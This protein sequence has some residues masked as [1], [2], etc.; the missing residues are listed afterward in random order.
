MC[1]YILKSF[2]QKNNWHSYCSLLNKKECRLSF[3]RILFTS[4]LIIILISSCAEKIPHKNFITREGNV[5]KD[6]D[7][8]FR[9]L[10]FNIPN[11]NFIEDEMYFRKP[12]PF[13]LPTSFEIRDAFESVKAMGGT[14]V[15]SY[16]FPVKRENDTLGIP[17]YVVGPGKFDESSFKVMDTVLAIA[18]E[19][20]I[21]LIV[22]L[23]NNWKWMGGVP[24]YA[25][26]RN[27]AAEEFW[28]D[29]LLI[30][31]FKKTIDFVLNREN[32][33]NGVA[34][35][36]DKSILC[37]ETGNELL[38]P[39]SW[40]KE[41]VSHI[42][43][44]DTN[45]LVMDGFNAIDGIDILEG[46]LTDSLV[47]IVSTHHYK[48]DPREIIKD[49]EK[50]LS[51]IDGRKPYII[52]EYGFL[53]TSAIE[54]ISDYL[55]KSKIAG[56]LL[57][58]LRFHREEGG[59]YWHSEPLGGDVFKAFH[60]P[61]F[62]SGLEYNE[63]ELMLMFKEKAY[64][65]RKLSV[66]EM[67]IPKPPILL[68]IKASS[69]ISW[70]GSV[71]AEYYDVQRSENGNTNWKTV[72]FNVSDADKFYRPLFDDNT[73]EVGKEYYYKITAKNISGT[74]EPSNIFGPVSYKYKTM[75]DE[76]ENITVIYYL[77]G[78]YALKN[79]N[80]RIFKEDA[81]RL[82]LKE[83]AELIYRVRGEINGARIFT[84]SKET[85]PSLKFEI[86]KDGSNYSGINFEQKSYFI[87]T[88][89]YSYWVPSEYVITP[90]DSLS[91]Y[92][93]FRIN[94]NGLNQIARIEIDYIPAEFSISRKDLILSLDK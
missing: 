66:P 51:R 82:E 78:E 70:K 10:S 18:D 34:Y 46:S 32:T 83:E 85:N 52:G 20:G 73:A 94:V 93:F 25:G 74:S 6:G 43:S 37:W 41:I 7:S 35:K 1:K 76:L 21:R 87:G 58:S 24:Q 86:S 15:R 23:L 12:H 3:I 2:H 16:T 17:R 5:L 89:D 71:G 19:V 60:Y 11:I 27:K 62:K 90:S 57:W 69:E 29:S 40:V 39:Y 59:F 77:N 72:G 92:S 79:N 88:R 84:F 63:R 36:N 31:D 8:T 38:S 67:E 45:H 4:Y 44:I 55:I 14:V 50:Q 22:P 68:P 9:F 26:F 56:G 80:D 64:E 48:L 61:G 30:S 42:K 47:D 28:Y 81:H 53:G 91:G 65:I 49:I 13:R 54:E 33:V 75:V